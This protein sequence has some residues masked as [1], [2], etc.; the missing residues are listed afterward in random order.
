MPPGHGDTATQIESARSGKRGAYPR[1]G[2]LCET[3]LTYYSSV[4]ISFS[5]FQALKARCGFASFNCAF[6]TLTF[7]LVD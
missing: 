1:K 3:G 7:T 5:T 6:G 4:M 2:I